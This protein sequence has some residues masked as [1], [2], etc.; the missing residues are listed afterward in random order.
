MAGVLAPVPRWQPLDGDGKPIPGARLYLH[1][2]GT[3]TPAKAYKDPYLLIRHTNPVI[4]DGDGRFPTIWLDQAVEYDRTLVNPTDP[5]AVPEPDPED[6]GTIISGPDPVDP[7]PITEPPEEEEE[8][9]EVPPV[10]I[11]GNPTHYV[12]PTADVNAALQNAQPGA[13]VLFAA[14]AEYVGNFTVPAKTNDSWLTLTSDG[15]IVAA[16]TRVGLAQSGTMPIFRSPNNQPVWSMAPNAK[17]TRFVGLEMGPSGHET[18]TA[19]EIG[20]PIET[21]LSRQPVDVVLDRV[22]ILGRTAGQ[23]RGLALHGVNLIVKECYIGDIK[24]AGFDTQAIF[25]NNG[26]GPYSITNSFLEAAGENFLVGGEDPRIS[27]CVPS[28]ITFEDNLL[29]KPS[30]WYGGP[31][32]VKNLF[33]LKTGNNVQARRNVLRRCWAQAQ[34]GDA[35]LFTPRNQDGSAPWNVVSNVI[36][37]YNRIE[38]VGAGFNILGTDNLNPS[39]RLDD[40]IIRHNLVV[41]NL[42]YGGSGRFIIMG[43]GPQNVTVRNNTSINLAGSNAFIYVYGGDPTLIAG[44][45]CR[46]NLAYHG[47]YGV[48]GAGVGTGNPA[49]AEFFSSPVFSGNVL[50]GAVAAGYS[51]ADYPVGNFFPTVAELE[52]EFVNFAG[53]D[54]ALDVGSPYT[55]KGADMTE[56]PEG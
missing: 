10:I 2:A 33:E 6:D 1:V 43:A 56:V 48:I 51:A 15:S 26:P 27:G 40:V 45:D 32:Q 8:P 25:I 19:M 44:F 4:A 46:D 37:E 47:T 52:A 14:G 7:D 53:G 28:D 5:T 22:L 20:S 17:R 42:A 11:V 18:G 34:D 30:S 23:K 31:W 55:G 50:A 41:V 35:V 36:F 12:P 24:G 29:E 13:S 21:V 49:F 3:S 39:G 38:D 9:T 54:Y 16:G